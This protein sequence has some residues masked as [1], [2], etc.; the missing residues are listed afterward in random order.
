MIHDLW[1]FQDIGS[2]LGTNEIALTGYIVCQNLAHMTL[3]KCLHC[4]CCTYSWQKSKNKKNDL[5]L[6][7]FLL[8]LH[9]LHHTYCSC[10][11]KTVKKMQRRLWSIRLVFGSPFT[12]GHS[13]LMISAITTQINLERKYY[14]CLI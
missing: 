9:H 6:G 4:K 10:T 2:H 8:S 11:W 7:C 5:L 3:H 14:C 1:P 12:V 13:S